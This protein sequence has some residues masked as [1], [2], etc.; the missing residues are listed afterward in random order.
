[1]EPQP[2]EKGAAA[3]DTSEKGQNH[4]IAHS[5]N[6]FMIPPATEIVTR[7]RAAIRALSSEERIC[8]TMPATLR[9][10]IA[11]VMSLSRV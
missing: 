10:P 1:M 4:I 6:S 3:H 8:S 11:Q 2:F 5:R 7:R 9:K